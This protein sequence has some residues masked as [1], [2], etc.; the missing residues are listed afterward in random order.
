V[1]MAGGTPVGTSTS[2]DLFRLAWEMTGGCLFVISPA[3]IIRSSF[4][5][6]AGLLGTEG[7][8]TPA[9][10]H[11]GDI[12]Q[13]SDHS[14]VSDAVAAAAQG[15]TA[16]VD[17]TPAGTSL[18][19]RRWRCTLGP[20]PT[21]AEG[22]PGVLAVCKDVT[23][24]HAA[25]AALD[26]RQT[27]HEA[28][29]EATS[30]IV[31]HYDA[32]AGAKDR[33]GWAEFTGGCTDPGGEFGW[34][35]FVHPDD[36]QP[37]RARIAEATATGRPYTVEYRL[38]HHSGEW[39]WVDDHAVPIVDPTGATTD[40]VGIVTD[41]HARRV[42]E[43]D[44]RRGEQQ[45]RMA[46]EATGL[47]IWDVDIATDAREWSSE[48][49]E[50]LG[51]PPGTVASEQVL[52]ER[53]HPE[54]RSAVIGHNAVTFRQTGRQNSATFRIIRGDT[55]EIRWI[56]SQGNVLLDHEGRPVRRIGTFQDITDQHETRQALRLALRRYE[57]LIAAT[58]EIVWHANATQE[59]G[60]G[61]GWTEFTGQT[62]GAANGDGWLDSVH[63]DDRAVAKRTCEE[64][65][66]AGT[67]YTNEYR[68]RHVSGEWR[69]VIDRVVPL[70][71]DDGSV[72]EWVGIIS[73]IHKRK[74]A[75]DKIRRAA[76]TDDLTGLGNRA[77][78][79]ISLDRAIERAADGTLVALLLID[80]DRFKEVND[81]LGHDA[82][83]AVLRT[84]AARLADSV[85]PGSTIAR[86]G[87]DEFGVILPAARGAEEVEDVAGA[88]LAELKQTMWFADREL[89]CSATIG[90]AIYP[91]QDADP[92]AL[93]KNADIALYA[94]KSAGRGQV[95]AF[96]PAMR[97]ELDRRIAVLRNAKD[98]L[99]R[100][101]IVPFYQPKVSLADGRIVG[102]EALLRW[103]DG[104]RLQSTGSM[105]EAFSDHDLSARIG[106]RMLERVTDDMQV[107]VEQ[108][109]RFGHIAI[110]VAAPELHQPSFV[111]SVMDSLAQ[112]GLSPDMLELE[113]TESVLIENGNQAVAR[114]LKALHAAGVAISLDDF[115]TGY[116]SLTH[117]KKF[118]VSWLKIDRSFVSNLECDKDSAAIVQAVL[119]MA[120]NIG[121]KVVAEGVETEWQYRF[122]QQNACDVAQGFLIAK[123]MAASRV[124]YFLA[125]RALPRVRLVSASS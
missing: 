57:A 88:I 111:A 59:V 49:K 22:F 40:W 107:W 61:T 43:G 115:G 98:A 102:F 18:A 42:T 33:R 120:R 66:A 17:C 72:T 20:Q 50:M 70:R 44:L 14:A 81:T 97:L 100:G 87:G 28:L 119:G 62:P 105:Q 85:P 32:V 104:S 1:T 9:G 52:L 90:L 110:N 122:L 11:F 95:F 23:E 58:S 114:T 48:L 12:W 65:L 19:G 51:L 37:I 4:G 74:T 109:V 79:Q 16:A 3:G 41:I 84:V 30:E 78:F 77:L 10:Q 94:A 56:R 118:P 96:R 112:R 38:L 125:S 21:E 55:G 86:L 39:R 121:I 29:I 7:A 82:G 91:L 68:L 53:V 71:D 113:I 5:D 101:A 89:D 15:R 116:A 69:W 60:D 46:I 26:K 76:H 63:P 47:G 25:A 45:L 108:G 73:D 6:M 13:S 54:D 93:L 80:L 35:A 8:T 123:P 24:E 34:L 64:A 117:L 92:S 2:A 75:E 36:R 103:W 99:A 83:D 27:L 31:W 124:P 106:T 67:P